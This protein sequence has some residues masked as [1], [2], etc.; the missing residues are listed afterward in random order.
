MPGTWYVLTYNEIEPAAYVR[1]CAKRAFGSSTLRKS[2]AMMRLGCGLAV[3]MSILR[4]IDSK[5][6]NYLADALTPMSDVKG[7]SNK[8]F[9]R[10]AKNRNGSKNSKVARAEPWACGLSTVTPPR[11]EPF[12]SSI[13]RCRRSKAKRCSGIASRFPGGSPLLRA[14]NSHR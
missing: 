8:L 3:G 1:R 13:G 14:A 2:L 9:S 12:R 11:Q 7:S 5:S 6:F 4:D 10:I